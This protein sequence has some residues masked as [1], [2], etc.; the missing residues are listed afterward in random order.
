MAR[1]VQSNLGAKPDFLAGENDTSAE[2][3]WGAT[4]REAPLRIPSSKMTL[5]DMQSH[6]SDVDLLSLVRVGN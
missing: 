1:R 6:L 4:S 2:N 5:Q 3:N